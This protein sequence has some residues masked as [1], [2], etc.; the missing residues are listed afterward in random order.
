MLSVS[1]TAVPWNMFPCTRVYTNRFWSCVATFI[2][3]RCTA[4]FG[5]TSAADCP[6]DAMFAQSLKSPSMRMIEEGTFG[7]GESMLARIGTMIM[8]AT[9]AAIPITERD[10]WGCGGVRGGGPGA[11]ETLKE[12][13]LRLPGDDQG[14]VGAKQGLVMVEG[15]GEMDIDDLR[16]GSRRGLGPPRG[17]DRGIFGRT[18]DVLD[19]QSVPILPRGIQLRRLREGFGRL[20][21]AAQLVE[22][23]S[24]VRPGPFEGGIRFEESVVVFELLGE[25]VRLRGRRTRRGHPLP[26]AQEVFHDAL[27]TGRDF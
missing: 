16:G 26:A 20:L 12:L 11:T 8:S 22:D 25:S 24:P 17:D 9:T 14:R 1:L 18:E 21:R 4:G 5:V 13:R 3:T 10:Q 7:P 15:F 19:L 6:Y 2:A 27:A 23:L